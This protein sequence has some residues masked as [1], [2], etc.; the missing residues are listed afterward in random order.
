[1]QHDNAWSANGT[2][3][4]PRFAELTRNPYVG[5]RPYMEGEHL[6]G[7]ERELLDVLTRVRSDRIVVMHSPSGAG[8]TSLLQSAVVPA[9]RGEYSVLPTIRV[10]FAA[11]SGTNRLHE[12]RY[13]HNT[14]LAMAE[15]LPE[16]L[17]GPALPNQSIA[18]AVDA[19]RAAT[20]DG[21]KATHLLV[22]D[23][24]EEIL[25]LDST[26]VQAKREFFS[27]LGFALRD[28]RVAVIIAMREEWLG[29]LEAYAKHLPTRLGRRYR[30]DPL[31][32]ESA[33]KAVHGPAEA[34]GAIFEPAAA[35]RIVD[36]L[37]QVRV[38]SPQPEPAFSSG[39]TVE[40][41]LL[42]VVCYSIWERKL[43]EWGESNE[44]RIIRESD[45]TSAKE[46]DSALSTYY[47]LQVQKAAA[48]SAISEE[49]LRDWIEKKLITPSGLRGHVLLEGSMAGGL[50]LHGV[51]ALE[52]TLLVR[53]DTVRAITWFELIH[54]RFVEPIR[55]ENAEWR[56]KFSAPLTR[57][58]E[59]WVALG[60]RSTELLDG[61][62]L[63]ALAQTGEYP[64]TADVEAYLA[65]SKV[66]LQNGRRV[67]WAVL[68]ASVILMAFTVLTAWMTYQEA[69]SVKL[70]HFRWVAGLHLDVQTELHAR[71]YGI[72]PE[73]APRKDEIDWPGVKEAIPQVGGPDRSREDQRADSAAA[74]TALLSAAA[75]VAG[76][77]A[78]IT[79][80][81]RSPGP[82]TSRRLA[83]LDLRVIHSPSTGPVP[84]SLA[85]SRDVPMPVIRTI[86]LA[87]LIDGNSPR[88]I[89][90]IPSVRNSISLTYEGPLR[91][92]PPLTTDQ[93]MRLTSTRPAVPQQQADDAGME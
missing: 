30:L 40:P 76:P 7:R 69:N 57:K 37:L 91:A 72:V 3:T 75:S 90:V 52:R 14:L 19:M 13:V 87:M 15:S 56:R 50:E 8:K 68:G 28:E 47:S 42:Q 64:V 43:V 26:D 18:Q 25:S 78:T 54:D 63:R 27:E 51:Q 17:K 66:A 86:A 53:R 67:R 32:R 73:P 41:L 84:N 35:S 29:E 38:A 1:M 12:N 48:T 23:Q 88:K 81:G 31:R 10:G 4:T 11:N 92:W 85:F 55:H 80:S 89:R 44:F 9:L 61:R 45:V 33:L 82:T 58:A 74:A 22:F 79:L 5:P 83:L 60:R 70:D 6:P 62:E 2:A 34:M 77:D 20:A 49:R 21:N 39:T 16:P 93:I 24:F 71:T 36:N 46:F 59:L 65:A